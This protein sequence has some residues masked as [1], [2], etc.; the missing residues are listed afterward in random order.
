MLVM[1]VMLVMFVMFVMLLA[2]GSFPALGF[3]L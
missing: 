3:L 1:L 2:S